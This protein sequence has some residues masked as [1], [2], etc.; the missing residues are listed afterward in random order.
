VASESVTSRRAAAG[1]DRYDWPRPPIAGC[2][3]A[4]GAT[5]IA[6]VLGVA[7]GLAE[8]GVDVR[9]GP[10]M[11]T[12][13]GAYAAAALATDVDF[14]AVMAAWPSQFEVKVS[15]A[16]RGHP[17]GFREPPRARRGR[18]RRVGIA[19]AAC[20][21]VVRRR[22]VRRCCRGL[23]LT[24]AVRVAAQDRRE[25]LHRRRVREHDVRRPRTAGGP[26][27][28]GH[29]DVGRRRAARH[30]DVAVMGRRRGLV[31]KVFVDLSERPESGHRR[32]GCIW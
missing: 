1:A 31:C 19:V 15:R 16:V 10:M 27:R 5:G 25:E 8:S 13:A 7:T 14:E 23:L 6:F 29:A 32:G 17:P 9:T 12:S 3:G 2:F 20:R 26:A 24:S 30:S 4:G 21:A 18:D 22:V 11:G 28:A